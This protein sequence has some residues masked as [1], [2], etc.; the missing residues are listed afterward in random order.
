MKSIL[1]LFFCMTLICV[2]ALSDNSVS[3]GTNS[4]SVH[5][6]DAAVPVDMRSLICEDLSRYF[7]YNPNICMVFEMT[8]QTNRHPLCPI[9]DSQHATNMLDNVELAM[10]SNGTYEIRVGKDLTDTYQNIL[11]QH[12]LALSQI[13]NAVTF[14]SH[15]NS[16]VVTNYTSIDKCRLFRT[17]ESPNIPTQT[18][19]IASGLVS[20]WCT[21]KYSLPALIDWK[22][23]RVWNGH[24]D[25]PVLPVRV[26]S[27]QADG[28]LSSATYYIGV[29][30]NDWFF[31][32]Y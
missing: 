15:F 21:Q 32:A 22:K 19:K 12:P 11:L 23:Q 10:L 18:E 29:I 13:S 5:F 20:F 27:S 30:S 1:G 4:C 25:I 8:S 3:I 2:V 6:A 26:C 24:P 28:I 17:L 31:I 7:S 9:C 16:G 14:V